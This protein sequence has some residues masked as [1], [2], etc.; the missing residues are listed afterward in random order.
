MTDKKQNRQTHGTP[1]GLPVFCAFCFLCFLRAEDDGALGFRSDAD[2]R[3]ARV[4]QRLHFMRDGQRRIEVDEN[5]RRDMRRRAPALERL[6]QERFLLR[7]AGELVAVQ[8]HAAR[9]ERFVDLP[10]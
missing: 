10:E 6:A 8:K 2:V 1:C 9:C 7:A 4:A 5:V 3:K